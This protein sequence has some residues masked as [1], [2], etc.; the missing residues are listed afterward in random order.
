M[1]VAHLVDDL[2]ARGVTMEPVGDRLRLV[3]AK[4][5]TPDE[6]QVLREHKAEVLELIRPDFTAEDV[7]ELRARYRDDLDDQERDQLRA[8]AAKDDVLAGA[9]VQAVACAPE[10][11]AWKLYSKKLERALWV[12]RDMA[13][14]A[15]L[16]ADGLPVVLADDLDRL[17]GWTDQRLAAVLEALAVFPGARLADVADVAGTA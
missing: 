16:P 4:L 10:P 14:V 6:L 12:A 7:A 5:V 8:D 13:A 9:I 11:C 15:D 3:P 1:T 17:R 2:L